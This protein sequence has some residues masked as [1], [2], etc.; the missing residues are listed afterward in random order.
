MTRP[1]WLTGG[2]AAALVAGALVAWG[3]VV[4]VSPDRD[5]GP[6][7]APTTS[8]GRPPP[9]ILTSA[10]RR[11]VTVGTTNGEQLSD[12]QYRSIAASYSVVVLAKFHAGWDIERHH[13]AVRRLKEL[14]PDLK[15]FGYMSTKY[16]FDANRWGADAIDPAW[17]LRDDTGAVV[18]LTKA[19]YDPDSK[20]LGTYVDT[21]NPAYR[22]WV[23][24]V[25]RSWMAAAPY[26]GIRF[27]AADPIGDYGDRDV[28]KWERLL[29]PK[30]IDAYNDGIV[31]LLS[32]ARSA[33]APG[34]VLFNGISPGPIR[35][36]G[37]D[38]DLL[39]V[40][41]GAMNETFCLSASGDLLDIE[42]DIEIMQHHP[43]KLLQLRTPS[44]VGTIAPTDQRRLER[45]CVA[46]FLLGWQPGASF[47]N[48]GAGYGTDQLDQ[49]PLDI[50]LDLGGPT[51]AMQQ[52]GGARRRRFEHGAVYVNLGTQPVSV[53]LPTRMVEMDGGIAV[54]SVDG[55]VTIAPHDAVLL[56]DGPASAPR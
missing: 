36:P 54:R 33:L 2:R 27:D 21:A 3:F 26:D 44:P 52:D 43:D 11:F 16:W 4:A 17:F 13:A 14:N 32:D 31:T 5:P 51:E 37:R 22:S 55:K 40:T 35:G 9:G 42:A 38:I 47:F 45:L 6:A 25:A 41:D 29:S 30:R 1:A 12:R 34:L 7:S 28:A 53:E 46:S 10:G 56:L 18:R 39:D 49:Q 24:G 50:D 19:S 8:V 15:V 23:L 48:M 20:S